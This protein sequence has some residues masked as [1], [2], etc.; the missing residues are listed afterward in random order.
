[1]GI[2]PIDHTV[3]LKFNFIIKTGFFLFYFYFIF[4]NSGERVIIQKI[5]IFKVFL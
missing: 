3:A 1:M 2:F 5:P 4:F